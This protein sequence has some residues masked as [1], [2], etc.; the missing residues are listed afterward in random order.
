[1]S[2]FKR[3]LLGVILLAVLSTSWA[4]AAPKFVLPSDLKVI[5]SGAFS[6]VDAGEIQLPEGVERIE[7]QAF[8]GGGQINL[9]D[10]LKHITPDALP[11]GI[12]AVVKPGSFAHLWCV[13]YHPNYRMQWAVG[14]RMQ[15]RFQ[16][17]GQWY[18]ASASSAPDV[19][20]IEED[21]WVAGIA[22]GDSV[23]WATTEM[24][25]SMEIDLKITDYSEGR[26]PL[27]VAHR[28][29]SGYCR[30]N[31][32]AAFEMANEMGADVV[33]L[34]VHRSKDGVIV[35]FHDKS[36]A[37]GDKKE[38]IANL[39][40][41]QLHKVDNRICTLQQAVDC[42]Q[43]TDMRMLVE[44]KAEGI[45]RQVFKIVEDGQMG[46]RTMYTSLNLN[47]LQEVEQLR[48]EVDICYP[49]NSQSLIDDILAHPEK[50]PMNIVGI[51]YQ[52]INEACVRDMHLIGKDVYAW[53]VNTREIIQT[54]TE[55]GVDGILTNY[56]DYMA[57]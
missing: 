10:S 39:T 15:V 14:Q 38:K 2:F 55:A 44:F 31:T 6:G 37:M 56:P 13:T 19:A 33:E 34:D 28:G 27:C 52:Y 11:A 8:T 1:M 12:T 40:Y 3:I 22:R 54:C 50:Y 51:H 4:M 7:S 17:D 47:I 20:R 53:T 42:I 32:I 57:G 48:P 25:L 23:I 43:K 30:E 16:T 36:I 18:I 9:P 35:V 45:A 46:D 5:E 29:A 21:G 24:G 41:K 26:R 49:V